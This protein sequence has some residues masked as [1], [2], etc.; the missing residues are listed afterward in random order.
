VNAKDVPDCIV[1]MP[2]ALGI[3]FIA[4]SNNNKRLQLS[5]NVKSYKSE[6]KF[7]S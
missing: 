6:Y 5:M 3:P 1:Q 7:Y 2:F 4:I